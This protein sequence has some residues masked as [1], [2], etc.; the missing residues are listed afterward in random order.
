MF[1]GWFADPAM[2][3]ILGKTQDLLKEQK[4]DWLKPEIAVFIDEKGHKYSGINESAM[5]MAMNE[6]LRNLSHMGTTYH[7]YL[8]SDVTEP[9]FPAD[10]YKLFIFVAAT[11]PTPEEAKAITEKL[12][13]N[14][15]TL[16][17]LHTG[18]CFNAQLSEFE[19]TI[20]VDG[21]SEK[22]EFKNIPYP[23][24]E[25]PILKFKDT[26]GYVISRMTESG[27][28]AVIWR[29]RKDY[30]VVYSLHLAPTPK[31][32]RHI[33]M[34]S[35]VHI[36]N[37]TGDCVYAGGEYVALHAVESGYRRINLPERGYRATDALTGQKVTV[38]DVY[39]DV[40]MEKFDTVVLHLER[41]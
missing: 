21:F 22:A 41:V 15:K 38:N 34:L 9:D 20:P 28:P 26:S 10:D 18:A 11:N 32:L 24:R 25:L 27:E 29:K 23:N 33:A 30:N 37:L 19:L 6:L 12:K 13:K 8:L 35:G 31:L 17:W 4:I 40:K 7:N 36:Y 39:I 5:S 14:G 3:K 1:G 2:Q 16:M